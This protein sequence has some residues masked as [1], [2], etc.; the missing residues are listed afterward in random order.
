MLHEINKNIFFENSLYII[1]FFLNKYFLWR[2]NA[3][4]LYL[5]N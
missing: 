4:N 1:F 5:F 2:N 3:N